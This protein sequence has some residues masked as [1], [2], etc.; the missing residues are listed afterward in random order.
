MITVPAPEPREQ[1]EAILRRIAGRR[2]DPREIDRIIA[3][4]DRYQATGRYRAEVAPCGTLAA[5]RRHLRRREP[6]D[7]ACRQAHN[8][9]RRTAAA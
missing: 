1:F 7:E 9:P 8:T 3:A 4:A 6:V 5:Y 2:L